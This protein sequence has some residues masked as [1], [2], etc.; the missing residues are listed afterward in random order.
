MTG[1]QFKKALKIDILAN[2]C[3]DL[4]EMSRLVSWCMNRDY[5]IKT[6]LEHLSQ[7]LK[8]RARCVLLEGDELRLHCWVGRYDCPMEPVPVCKES[9]VWKAVED[10]VPLNLTDDRQTEGYDHTLAEKIKFKA[11]IPLWYVDSMTQE[12]KRVGALI[13]DCG[14]EGVPIPEEDFEYLK[15]V[16]ELIGAAVGK[17]DIT[18]QLIESCVKKEEIVRE[19]AHAFRNRIASLGGICRRITRMTKDIALSQEVGTLDLEL[20][21]LESHLERFEK[22]I[23]VC[24]G[25]GPKVC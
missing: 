25:F 5:L 14:K 20:K 24:Q 4:I 1:N 7:G 23:E 9:I 19:T 12:E 6:C 2:R 10:N 15:L 11:V 21:M 8:K 3:Q 17:A 16:G 22:N 18:E 13:V